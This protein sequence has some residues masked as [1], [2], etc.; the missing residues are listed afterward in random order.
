MFYRVSNGGSEGL[1]ENKYIARISGVFSTGDIPTQNLYLSPPCAAVFKF[2][3]KDYSAFTVRPS[4]YVG[5][6]LF[7]VNEQRIDTNYASL[8]PTVDEYIFVICGGSGSSGYG[9]A[10]ISF[11]KR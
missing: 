8:D 2:S 7:A 6:A 10:N 5:Y 11:T 9:D 1:G 3:G 4:S